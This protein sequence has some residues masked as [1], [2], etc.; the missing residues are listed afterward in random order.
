[1]RKYILGLIVLPIFLAACS[2]ENEELYGETDIRVLTSPQAVS[3]TDHS[4]VISASIVGG[5][6][7][8]TER[9][10]Y[11]STSSGI[12][13]D[14][15]TPKT[16]S[17][18]VSG[19]SFMTSIQ[20][21]QASTTYYARAYVV[22]RGGITLGNEISFT[23][24]EP[25]TI[26]LPALA[27]VSVE[28]INPTWAIASSEVIDGDGSGLGERGICCS[29]SEN[30]TIDDMKF[31]DT[32]SGLG[33]FSVRMEGLTDQTTYYVRAYAINSEGVGYSEQTSFVA[34][35]IP[36]VP[37]MIFVDEKVSEIDLTTGSIT[38]QITD[39][40]GET[41]SEYGVYYGKTPD[42]IT[43]KF[44]ET[45]N[46]LDAEGRVK[47]TVT[48]LEENNTYYLQAYAVNNSGIGY[49]EQTV[50]FHTAIDGG[51]GLKYYILDPILAKIGTTSVE[52]EFLDRNL[53]ATRVAQS[54][55]DKEAYGWMFQWGRR[56]DG[57]QEVN[58]GD[59]PTFVLG[60]SDNS[61][62]PVD[63]NTQD[64]TP[65]Y[66]KGGA[67][68]DWV[69]NPNQATADDYSLNYYWAAK[70]EDPNYATGGTNNPCP[71][72]FKIPTALEWTAITQQCNNA[73]DIYD[74][75]KAPGTGYVKSDG[76][77]AATGSSVYVWASDSG[78]GQ[79]VTTNKDEKYAGY[80]MFTTGKAVRAMDKA[81]AMPVR[82]IKIRE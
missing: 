41:P 79:G 68:V 39:N 18:S 56:A 4:A 80:A 22:G 49:S 33:K 63:R 77:F 46:S 47:I 5:V 61:E 40:G 12:T 48:G 76:T 81:A 28:D 25:G 17:A 27:A 21:L 67:T 75:I 2:G 29:T 14:S 82:C 59:K 36:K 24:G 71:R 1:M 70:T 50:S 65:F 9:G 53:G 45:T 72:G 64:N 69:L 31:A 55:D 20:N 6:S 52:L 19:T 34:R 37:K 44:I 7:T 10:V 73:G 16:T 15:D 60:V 66:K 32:E 3:I 78:T 38:I 30:P 8:V 13:A 26:A 74:L 57:H 35:F 54:L 42:N 58:W 51:N 62:A 43:T 23:T 11:Y